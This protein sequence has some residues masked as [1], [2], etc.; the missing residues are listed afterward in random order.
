[1]E[2]IPPNT[3]EQVS[4]RLSTERHEVTG[5]SSN[6]TGKVQQREVTKESPPDHKSDQEDEKDK[7]SLSEVNQ[8]ADQM[9]HQRIPRNN[10]SSNWPIA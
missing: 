1:M 6:H 7:E 3:Q 8:K 2:E 5:E 9:I 10:E 4:Q